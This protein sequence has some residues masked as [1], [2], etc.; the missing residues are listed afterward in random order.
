MRAGPTRTSSFVP[1]PRGDSMLQRAV[2][3][4]ARDRACRPGR[5]RR[6][7][8]PPRPSSS[9]HSC[10]LRALDLER[11]ARARRLRMPCDVGRRFAQHQ[12]KAAFD[13]RRQSGGRR[14]VVQ[15]HLRG[16]EQQARGREFGGEV[17]RSGCRS[18]RCALRP[19][20]GARRVRLLPVRA[21]SRADRVPTSLRASSSFSVISDSVWPSR[22]CR[23]RPMRSRSA[24]AARRRT[25]SCDSLS[26]ASFSCARAFD[27]DDHADDQRH[28]RHPHA[29][30][31]TDS[32]SA[33][34]STS[35][36]AR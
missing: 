8:T 9:T 2:H 4:R 25:S 33:T 16:F 20:R 36:T 17:A 15:V 35:A 23:S 22:S 19:A 24:V 31:A 34:R 12:R 6:P 18:P 11:D 13:V 32:R 27:V 29:W 30:P 7:A 26:A 14:G 21:A 3:A 1:P 5:C 28:H 10:T